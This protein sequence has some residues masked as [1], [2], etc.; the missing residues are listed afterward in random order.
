VNEKGKDARILKKSCV[1]KEERI[2]NTSEREIAMS[3][4]LESK[5]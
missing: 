5:E 4:V 3:L 2:G 1:E